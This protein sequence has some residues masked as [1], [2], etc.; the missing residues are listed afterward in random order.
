V[1]EIQPWVNKVGRLAEEKGKIC[2]CHTDGENEGLMALYRQTNFHVAESLC[3]TPMTN[4]TLKQFREGVGP[5]IATWGGI[6]AVALIESSMSD[7]D[8]EK[9]LDTVF[10]ELGTGER[11]IFG[12]SDNVPPEASLER[13]KSLQKRIQGFGAVKPR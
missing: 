7:A 1:Q 3:T 12:V 2:C 5:K 6:P 13:M 8:F 4:Y 11:L 9:H 10:Q